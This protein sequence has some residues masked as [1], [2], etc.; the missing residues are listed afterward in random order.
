VFSGAFLLEVTRRANARETR[1]NDQN[2]QMLSRHSV[3]LANWLR[4]AGGGDKALR[5]RSR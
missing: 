2:I 3:L 1:A 4:L 5:Q